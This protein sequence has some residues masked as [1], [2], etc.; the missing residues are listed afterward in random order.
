[1][2]SALFA[3]NARRDQSV[4]P[5]LVAL[6]C[7]AVLALLLSLPALNVPSYVAWS[8]PVYAQPI[9]LVT[10]WPVV[11]AAVGVAGTYILLWARSRSAAAL[12]HIAALGAAGVLVAIWKSGVIGWTFAKGSDG[13]GWGARYIG[14]HPGTFLY[15]ATALTVLMALGK[16]TYFRYFAAGFILILSFFYAIP[17]PQSS[18]MPEFVQAFVVLGV[19][20]SHIFGDRREHPQRIMALSLVMLAALARYS[21]HAGWWW[22]G[23]V[24]VAQALLL[25]GAGAWLKERMYQVLGVLHLL[26]LA[27][28]YARGKGITL[29]A[30]V[31][32]IAASLVLFAVALVITFKKS[33]LLQRIDGGGS[34][35]TGVEAERAGA[36]GVDVPGEIS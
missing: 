5:H 11:S 27:F 23:A 28:I 29:H 34:S 7:L 14:E 4:S 17:G 18:L 1:M 20:L 2:F 35:G 21:L 3:N 30:P 12:W 16:K 10:W 9:L 33:A 32:V 19:V 26:L 25:I 36:N 31:V 6:D 8:R 15:S 22:T 13:I 24:V